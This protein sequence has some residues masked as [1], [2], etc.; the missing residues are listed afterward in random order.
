MGLGGF[1]KNIFNPVRLKKRTFDPEKVS[2]EDIKLPRIIDYFNSSIT[3]SMVKE[4][5][6]TYSSLN[7][8]NKTMDELDN[9]EYHSFQIGII[10][11]YLQLDY[12]LVV[13]NKDKIFPSFMKNI[14]SDTLQ[15]KV[16]DII[17]Q[18][19]KDIPKDPTGK[20]FTLDIR[21]TPLDAKYLLYYLT[22]YKELKI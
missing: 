11:K 1:V 20:Q 17:A 19:D 16:F 3:R 13:T 4:E 18:Y 12:D 6:S 9:K 5:I 14:P 21:W 15:V 22:V 2:I 10:L 8:K 7:Y